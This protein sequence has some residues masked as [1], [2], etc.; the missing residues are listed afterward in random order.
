M[1]STSKKEVFP[2]IYTGD[3]VVSLVEREGHRIPNDIFEVLPNSSSGN[4]RYKTTKHPDYTSSNSASTFRKA[5]SQEEAW[6]KSTYKGDRV[7]LNLKDMPKVN[8]TY[9]IY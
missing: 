4:L 3:I 8:N 7:H 6:Y 1:Q 5:T 2:G 9:Q